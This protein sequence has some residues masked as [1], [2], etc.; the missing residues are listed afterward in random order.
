MSLATTTVPDVFSTREVAR[1]AGVDQDAVRA[2]VAGG[3]IRTVTGHY[4]PSWEAVRAVRMLRDGLPVARA[5]E[6][7]RPPARG[8][9]LAHSEANDGDERWRRTEPPQYEAGELA[10]HGHER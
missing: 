6:L 3:L 8:E 2:L 9:D 5:D 1:A 7:F 4:L 10:V